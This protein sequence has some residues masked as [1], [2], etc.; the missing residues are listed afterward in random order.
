MKFETD[1][2]AVFFLH[3]ID[4]NTMCNSKDT[5]VV[6]IV[7]PIITNLN[8]DFKSPPCDGEEK[9][10]IVINS[11]SGGTP[12]FSYTINGITANEKQVNNLDPGQ[13]S[14]KVKDSNGCTSEKKITIEKRDNWQLNLLRDSV[15]EWGED[16]RLLAILSI[17]NDK[18]S[19]IKWLKNGEVFDTSLVLS[20]IE[21][22]NTST[23]YEILVFDKNGC[24]RSARVFL[25][26]KFDPKIYAP[27]IFSPNDDGINDR[28]RLYPNKYIKSIHRLDIYDRWGE[29][30]FNQGYMDPSDPL[31]GWDGN[32]RDQ[33]MNNAVFVWVAEVEFVNGEKV[34]LKGDVL[35]LR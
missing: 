31:M 3:V 14:I 32:F 22:P 8:A 10:S 33:P 29:W 5:V 17:E 25:Q 13:Y 20:Q 6:S 11:T 24:K 16:I 35:L 19:Q 12:P 21:R 27:N 30:I 23:A 9:G 28:F 7:D 4:L 2:A 26:V 1:S 34:V 18:I 15:L